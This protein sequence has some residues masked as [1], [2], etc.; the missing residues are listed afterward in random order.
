MTAEDLLFRNMEQCIRRYTKQY[1]SRDNKLSLEATHQFCIKYPDIVRQRGVVSF[2][3]YEGL[4]HRVYL[5]SDAT[6]AQ[7]VKMVAAHIKKLPKKYPLILIAHCQNF[8]PD[9]VIGENFYRVDIHIC[10]RVN[11]S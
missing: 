6:S 3:D 1:M 11:R 8:D 4:N 2:D 5:P 7:V 9:N 10:D